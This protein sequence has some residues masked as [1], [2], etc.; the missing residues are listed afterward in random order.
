[1]EKLRSHC[2]EQVIKVN[3]TSNRTKEPCTPDGKQHHFLPKTH[4]LNL[5]MRKQQTNPNR[6]AFYQK[7]N[8]WSVII[9]K[10]PGHEGQGKTEKLSQNEGDQRD[11]TIK[12][13]A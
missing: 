11:M 5:I 8:H 7:K 4:N 9:F 13:K 3:I 10:C 6:G 2:P 1:M 12:S